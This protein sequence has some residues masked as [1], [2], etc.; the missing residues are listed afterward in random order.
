MLPGRH[1]RPETL[2]PVRQSA[3]KT[4]LSYLAGP[5]KRGETGTPQRGNLESVSSL[6][7]EGDFFASCCEE[8]VGSKQV[9][10]AAWESWGLS[11]HLRFGGDGGARYAP[12]PGGLGAA[13]LCW[14]FVVPMPEGVEV[15]AEL[16]S[17]GF[18]VCHLCWV[19]T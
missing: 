14:C 6:L 8:C 19:K 17:D 1:S 12:P 2:L 10:A 7:A 9:L 3:F 16:P 15:C 4:T 11:S 18:G 13:V 5:S